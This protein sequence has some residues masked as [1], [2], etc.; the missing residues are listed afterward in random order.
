M[1]T[2]LGARSLRQHQ[3]ASVP[4]LR[5][6]TEALRSNNTEYIKELALAAYLAMHRGLDLQHW[7][8][9]KIGHDGFV[10]L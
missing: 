2:I 1:A 4:T 8:E 9:D 3:K 10:Q 7:F 6:R 5:M